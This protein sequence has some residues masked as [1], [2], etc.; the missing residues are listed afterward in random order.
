MTNNKFWTDDWM[1]VQQQYWQKLSEF[2]QQAMNPQQ[3]KNAWDAGNWE[4]AMNQWFKTIAPAMPDANQGFMEKMIEQGTVF[5]RMSEQLMGNLEKNQ[6]WTEALQQTF[7]QLQASFATQ[8]ERASGNLEEGFAKMMG[9]WQSPMENFRQMGNSVDINNLFHKGPNLFEKLLN[10]PGLGY[11]RED[12]ERYKQF[13]QSAMHYQHAMADYN[14]FFA[15]I[16]TQAVSCMKDDVQA[17]AD[18]GE[19]IESGRQLYN[20]WVGACER[21]Y[22]EHALTPE[23]AKVHGELV[24]ALM[25]LK[26]QWQDIVDQ[27]LGMMNLPTRREIKTLQTRLQESRREVRSLQCQMNDLAEEVAAM[28]QQLLKTESQPATQPANAEATPAAAVKKAVPRKKA[29]RKKAAAKPAN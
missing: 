4:N 24:N 8:A 22:S 15:N 26:K 18:K 9:F 14:R 29:S 16:G 20:I 6:N 28:K 7:Q 2:G 13:M 3:P 12:E 1:Q 23:Y 19:K 17:L 10:A 27:R 11:T 5:Y 25:S 21:V